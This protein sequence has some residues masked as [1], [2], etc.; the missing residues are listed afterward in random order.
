MNSTM[1]AGAHAMDQSAARVSTKSSAQAYRILHFGFTVAPILA[2]LDKFFNLLTDWEKYL[3]GF[4]TDMLGGNGHT[5]MMIVGVI[6]IAAGIGV[7]L[8]P[9]I[10]SYVVAAWLAVIIL[11]LL[12]IPGYF[13]IAL[14]DFGLLLG[15]LALGQLSREHA[16]R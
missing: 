10:F 13:D 15:A 3:P 5:L 14:R 2:G 4:V 6:E 9:R 12:L 16:K 8:K 11:N 1:S 7:A